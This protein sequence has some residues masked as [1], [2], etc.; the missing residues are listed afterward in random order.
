MSPNGR[1]LA[2]V[3][4]ES[5]RPEVYVQSFPDGQDGRW[6]VSSNGGGAPIWSRDGTEIFYLSL[7]NRITAV[8]VKLTGT[9]SAGRPRELFQVP[10]ALSDNNGNAFD[11]APD[12]RFLMSLPDEGRQN[13]TPITVVMNWTGLLR[14]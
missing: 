11:V 9:F 2:Y 5:G 3:S 6:Q 12:G 10:L 8:P 7:E 14:Q 13:A 4:D 1:W